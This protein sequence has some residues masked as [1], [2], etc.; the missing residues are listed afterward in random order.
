M[1][2]AF[3]LATGASQS[4]WKWD[5]AKREPYTCALTGNS[6]PNCIAAAMQFGKAATQRDLCQVDGHFHSA[7]NTAGQLADLR[8]TQPG[9]LSPSDDAPAPAHVLLPCLQLLST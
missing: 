5:Q 9:K 8:R 1:N 6:L 2:F 7:L 4:H 3:S